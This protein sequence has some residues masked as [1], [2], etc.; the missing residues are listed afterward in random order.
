MMAARIVLTVA[1]MD[2]DAGWRD[3]ALSVGGNSREAVP[4]RSIAIRAP[5]YPTARGR[6]CS[7]GPLLRPCVNTSG[8]APHGRCR[9]PRSRSFAG[10]TR[11]KPQRFAPLLDIGPSQRL[12]KHRLK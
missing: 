8:G 7:V 9:V 3:P 10:T 12:C 4:I 6:L 2:A 11:R 1:K 5:G